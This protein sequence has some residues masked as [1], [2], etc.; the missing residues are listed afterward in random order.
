MNNDTKTAHESAAAIAADAHTDAARKTAS[1]SDKPEKSEKKPL[2]KDQV[3]LRVVALTAAFLGIVFGGTVEYFVGGLLD[4][5]GWFGPTIDN[6]VEEQNANFA[7][8]RAKLDA[9]GK[10]AP[11]SPEAAAL[12]KEINALVATQEKLTGRTHEE[13]ASL[14]EALEAMRAQLLAEKGS[15]GGADFWLLMNE[16]VTLREAGNVFSLIGVNSRGVSVDVN[17]SGTVKRLK[18][19]DFVEFQTSDSN[20]KVFYKAGRAREDGRYGFDLVCEPK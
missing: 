10:A 17:L 3:K 5:T 18:P 14:Q 8:L 9:L 20:C 2:T 4:S 19:G 16:G 6:I 12:Q 11:G 1:P 13:I 15:A 7:D